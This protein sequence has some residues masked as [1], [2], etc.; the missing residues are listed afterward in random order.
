M[1]KWLAKELWL[2]CEWAGINLGRLAPHV[3][4]LMIGCKPK[5]VEVT[6]K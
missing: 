4:G 5:K 1:V 3:F 6:D 2:F